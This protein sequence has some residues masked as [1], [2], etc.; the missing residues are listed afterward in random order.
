MSLLRDIQNTAVDSASDVATLLRKCKILA[1]RLGNSDFRNW[2]D[3]ELNGYDDRDALPDYRKLRVE[4]VGHFSGA[5][6]SGLRNAPIPPVCLPAE[7]RESIGYSYLMQPISAYTSLVDKQER[8]NAQE[9]WPADLV[10]LVGR[11]IYQHMNCMAAWK[12]IPYNALVAL[13]DTIKTRVLNFSLE[14]EAQAPHAGEATLH[15]LPLPQDKVSQVFNTY[16]TG[17]VQNVATGGSHFSQHTSSNNG[18]SDEVFRG[19]IEALAAVTNKQQEAR[20]LTSAAEEMRQAFGS[21]SF[22]AR[23]KNFMSLLSDHIQVF[24]PVVAPYLPALAAFVAQ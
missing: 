14:I 19:L 9:N 2:V 11:D 16:I 23:Y 12:I 10:A 17:S 15:E 8:S 1:V 7:L 3:R 4:S 20:R 22:G 24:G 5:F 18:A 21:D 13:I 6:N